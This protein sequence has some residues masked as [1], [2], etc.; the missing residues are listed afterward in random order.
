MTDRSTFAYL[1]DV[2]VLQEHAGKG[3]GVWLVQ[4]A[5]EMAA[6][7][8]TLPGTNAAQDCFPRLVLLRTSTAQSL[9][10]RY[11]GF[12]ELRDRG[13]QDVKIMMRVPQSIF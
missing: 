9:Y 11:A 12:A 1:A 4:Q 5:Q 3:L 13:E 10:S 6:V 7:K 8:R 2:F